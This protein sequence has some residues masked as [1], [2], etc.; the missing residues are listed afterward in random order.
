[1]QHGERQDLHDLQK[2]NY[3]QPRLAHPKNQEGIEMHNRAEGG[4]AEGRDWWTK[5]RSDNTRSGSDDYDTAV[6]SSN[7]DIQCLRIPIR[8]DD[9][10]LPR[11]DVRNQKPIPT[12][13]QSGEE[14]SENGDRE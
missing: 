14:K 3:G 11:G 12:T 8:I 5:G 1:M 10:R 13:E 2:G 7:G 9:V 4:D 6:A